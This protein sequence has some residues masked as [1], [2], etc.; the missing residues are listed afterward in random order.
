MLINLIFNFHDSNNEIFK[1]YS[2]RTSNSK[3][4]IRPGSSGSLRRAIE[5]P[6]SSKNRESSKYQPETRRENCG[7]RKKRIKKCFVFAFIVWF[8]LLWK[9]EFIREEVKL[10]R[11]VKAKKSVSVKSFC[12]NSL[13]TVKRLFSGAVSLWK[14]LYDIQEKNPSLIVPLLISSL[15]LSWSQFLMFFC[16]WNWKNFHRIVFVMTSRGENFVRN[17][18]KLWCNTVGEDFV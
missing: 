8:L 3:R 11:K 5:R 14:T 12:C 6:E 4:V 7:R 9:S 10:E 13:R 16:K 17:I 2:I 15:E 18:L 1:Y